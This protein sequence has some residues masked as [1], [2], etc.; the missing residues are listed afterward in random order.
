MSKFSRLLTRLDRAERRQTR[1]D[2][3]YLWTLWLPLA[4]IGLA[5]VIV[6]VTQ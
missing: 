3:A 2:D 4:I 6:W 5:S 1:G